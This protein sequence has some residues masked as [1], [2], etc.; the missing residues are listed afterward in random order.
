MD[1]APPRFLSYVK[2]TLQGYVIVLLVA[3]VAGCLC[4][5]AINVGAQF[6][7]SEE[8]ARTYERTRCHFEDSSAG[9]HSTDVRKWHD[10]YP[11]HF[12]TGR[13]SLTYAMRKATRSRGEGTE[14]DLPDLKF[15]RRTGDQL[16]VYTIVDEATLRCTRYAYL[17]RNNIVIYSAQRAPGDLN[18]VERQTTLP[19]RYL[20]DLPE[21]LTG[22]AVLGAM[23]LVLLFAGGY[24]LARASIRY[25]WALL[26]YWHAPTPP[27]TGPAEQV[28]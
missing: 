11:G 10:W 17:L 13:D 6:L 12:V 27:K 25:G 5:H 2:F 14:A 7:V 21:R 19:G 26:K 22:L 4:F 8:Q 15:I 28:V 3:A 1:P 23:F 16:E 9:P 18:W 20:A 24:V